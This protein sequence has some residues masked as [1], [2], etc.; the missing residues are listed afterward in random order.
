M[1]DI[2]V[3]IDHEVFQKLK[4]V[5]TIGGQTVE[6]GYKSMSKGNEYEKSHFMQPF[7]KIFLA[8]YFS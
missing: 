4:K 8:L 2:R 1:T 3:T 5:T 6:N 7:I